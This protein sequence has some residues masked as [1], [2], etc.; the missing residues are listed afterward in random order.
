MSAVY[1]DPAILWARALQRVRIT[2]QGCWEYIG[3]TNSQGYACLSAGAKGK[4]I[5]GHRLAVLVRD[6]SL[7][8]L[9][10]D[11]L[12]M[13][14]ICFR[15]DH[16]EVVTTAENN[17]RMRKA[18]GYYIGG[19]CGQGHALTEESAYTS[20]RGRLICRDCAREGKRKP[21]TQLIRQWAREQGI[22]V[23]ARGRL[24]QS[25]RDQY[26]AAQQPR[27]A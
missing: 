6:G 14:R 4:T 24:P 10:V 5:L 15:P 2:E 20:K 22:H 8:N 1:R 19:E 3:A 26:L 17:R 21:E 27:A 25:L 18:H 12:C 11:H 13:N 9:P 7:S 16:L 23:A